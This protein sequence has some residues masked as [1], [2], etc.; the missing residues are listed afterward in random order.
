MSIK[1]FKELV[2]AAAAMEEKTRIV[3]VNAQDEHTL[4]AIVRATKD[5]IINPILVGDVAKIS[6]I[7]THEGDDPAKYEIIPAADVDE[8][9]AIAVKLI[10]EGKGNVLMKGKLQTGEMMKAVVNKENNLRTGK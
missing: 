1:N 5:G 3:V 9:L 2:A 6:E 10:Q 8:S 4:D 7:I